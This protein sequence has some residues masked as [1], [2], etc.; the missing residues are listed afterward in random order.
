[1]SPCGDGLPRADGPR[2][3]SPRALDAPHRR[4]AVSTQVAGRSVAAGSFSILDMREE[5]AIRMVKMGGQP[6]GVTRDET[7]G[8]GFVV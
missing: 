5:R 4:A 8:Q 1:M 6:I 7:L 2:R 3:P